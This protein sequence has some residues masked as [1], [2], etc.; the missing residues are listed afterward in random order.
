MERHEQM[1]QIIYD[2][3]DEINRT[4]DSHKTL[5]KSPETILLGNGKLDSLEFINFTIAVEERV[6]QIFHQ[7]ISV[8]DTALLADESEQLTVGILAGRI[9]ELVNDEA[10]PAQRAQPRGAGK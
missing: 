1:V 4:L 3:I 8:I 6:D 10:R 2:A 9:A 7:T 5:Q